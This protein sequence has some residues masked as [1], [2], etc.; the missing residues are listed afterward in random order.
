MEKVYIIGHLKPDTD[1]ITSSISLAYLKRQLGINAIPARIGELN[2]ET[3]YV[4]DYFKVKSPIL[5]NDVKLQLKDISY[6]KDYYVKENSTIYDTYNYLIDNNITGVCVVDD[7]NKLISLVTSTIILKYLISDNNK[8]KTS[9]KNIIRVLNGQSILD[10]DEEIDSSIILYTYNTSVLNNTKIDDNILI[11]NDVGS[12]IDY[13]IYHNIKLIILTDNS[14]I[15]NE[16]LLKAEKKRINIIKT[17]LSKEEVF[18]NIKLSNYISDIPLNKNIITFNEDD[19]YDEF[20][21]K[22]SKSKNNNYPIVSSDGSCKGLIRITDI[23]E[24]NK[25]KVILVDHN[26]KEQ[27]ID[28]LD[29]AEILEIVDHHKLGD[30]ST[31][32]PINVR[33]MVVG[34][35]NTIIYEMY[36]E[37]NV[38]IPM[39]IAGIMLAGILSDTLMLTSPTTTEIDKN[40][41]ASLSITARVDYKEFALNMFKVGTSIEGKTI[42]KIVN[43]DIKNFVSNTEEFAVSQI[44]TLDI[45]SILNRKGEF[46]DYINK[47]SKDRNYRM[48]LLVVTDI[49]KNGSYLLYSDN[50]SEIVSLAFNIDNIT[51]GIYLDKIVSRK[52]QIIPKIMEVM[53]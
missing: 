45:D 50:S 43:N 30:I 44:F 46:I 13:F 31:N 38:S 4:L 18:N 9:L 48:V 8:I 19:Y 10:F 17:S 26:E 23:F 27:S 33:N 12:V 21:I 25:K 39:Q 14:M 42:E 1:S 36:K 24:K 52:K 34:S 35:T 7:D 2:R 5:L 15:S 37:N 51:Q 49:V 28:G 3:R 47:F 40:A 29:E 32:I 11:T 20:M 6:Y 16:A 53:R 41:V 22:T